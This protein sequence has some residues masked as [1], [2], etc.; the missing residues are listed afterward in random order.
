[1]EPR[2]TYTKRAQLLLNQFQRI[3][4]E[5]ASP[6]VTCVSASPERVSVCDTID[7]ELERD[8]IPRPTRLADHR[9][10][11][12]HR[13]RA[14]PDGAGRDGAGRD[15][16]RGL[17]HTARCRSGIACGAGRV[18][19]TTGTTPPLDTPTSPQQSAAT[20]NRGTHEPHRRPPAPPLTWWRAAVLW[21]GIVA[22]L[23]LMVWVAVGVW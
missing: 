3:Y 7:K 12:R 18:G 2:I 8:A 17:S 16:R 9:R 13:T 22:V 21:V 1:V 11:P 15:E 19:L 4:R 14:G 5:N 23:A 20:P 10:R 6:C